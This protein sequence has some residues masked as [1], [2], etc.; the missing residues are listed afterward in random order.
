MDKVE[1]TYLTPGQVAKLLMVSPAALRIWAEKGEINALITPGGHRRFLPSEVD[2]FAKE[3]GLI[4]HNI[5]DKKISVLIVDDEVQFSS[6]LKKLLSK[7]PDYIEVDVANNGFD[8][9]IKLNEFKPDV[10]LLDL[11]MPDLD[12]FDVCRKIKSSAKTS[13]IRVIAMTGY[14]SP[15]NLEKILSLG[16][17]SCLSKPINKEVLLSQLGIKELIN[18]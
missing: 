1:E 16:A 7:Y 14:P 12:G 15:A 8:A 6:Y 2:R 9:G 11:M 3:R 4:T 10:I 13:D 5:E 17:E 18:K